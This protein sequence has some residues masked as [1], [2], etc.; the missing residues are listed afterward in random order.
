[1]RWV[2]L[3]GCTAMVI[4]LSGCA[5]MGAGKQVKHLESQVSLLDERVTQLE[6][7]TTREPSTAALPAGEMFGTEPGAVSSPAPRSIAPAPVK[8][9]GIKPTTRE[10]Q[11]ALKN[12]GFYQGKIDGKMGPM[13][14]QAVQEFQKINGLTPDG[15]IGKKTWAKLGAYADASL[16]NGELNAAEPL[17]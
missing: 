8:S 2:R 7:M 14:R 4:L 12:A 11:Q 17:K 5:S 13:T 3:F 15:V 10:I 16:G 1:M 9:A 6:R